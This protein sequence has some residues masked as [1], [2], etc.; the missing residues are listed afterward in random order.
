MRIGTTDND[1]CAYE[2][3]ISRGKSK[4]LASKDVYIPNDISFY[5]FIL[6]LFLYIGAFF[7]RKIRKLIKKTIKISQN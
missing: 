2:S 6:T 4:R 1:L 3:N 5:V 7:T